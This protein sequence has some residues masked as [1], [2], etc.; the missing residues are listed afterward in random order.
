MTGI[1]IH[2]LAVLLL[3][4]TVLPPVHATD[5]APKNVMLAKLYYGS[6]TGKDT[7]DESDPLKKSLVKLIGYPHYE[8]LGCADTL[9]DVTYSQWLLPCKVFYLEF[10]PVPEKPGTFQFELF[11]DKTSLLSGEFR[12]RKRAPLIIT[13][14]HYGEGRLVLIIT[15]CGEDDLPQEI[16]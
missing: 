7:L 2:H 3:C 14:P 4:A 11:K 13:G 15:M 9:I 12:P 6:E 10:K 16:K 1:R 5:K 8:K